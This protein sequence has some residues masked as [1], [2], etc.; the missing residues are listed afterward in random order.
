MTALRAVRPNRAWEARSSSP[1][2]ASTS[3]IR[4]TPAAR[5]VVADEPRSRAGRGATSSV[6]PRG[7]RGRRSG[8]SAGRAAGSPGGPSPDSDVEALDV[9]GISSP[10]TVMKPGISRVRKSSA[11]AEVFIESQK[12]RRNGELVVGLRDRRDREERVEDHDHAADE[13]QRLDDRRGSRR[14]SRRRTS[15]S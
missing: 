14:S 3:T 7:A 13:E 2:Y 10:K 12:S 8:G 5:R 4:A 1:M 9:G 6:G 15:P 11:V